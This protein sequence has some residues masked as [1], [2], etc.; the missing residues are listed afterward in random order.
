MNAACD[1]SESAQLVTTNTVQSLWGLK[2]AFASTAHA[3]LCCAVTVAASPPPPLAAAGCTAAALRH[4]SET[5][6][7]CRLLPQPPVLSFLQHTWWCYRCSA[8]A[9]HSESL[10]SRSAAAAPNASLS[11]L[12]LRLRAI[13]AGAN[14]A[15]TVTRQ[16]KSYNASG[17]QTVRVR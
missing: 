7:R 15:Y 16:E 4:L 14:D 8:T 12:P 2:F 3:P 13:P 11:F 10:P 5:P 6:L 17:S 1:D 9:S